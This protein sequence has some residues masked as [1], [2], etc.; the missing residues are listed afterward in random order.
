MI[1]SL[2]AE[3]ALTEFSNFEYVRSPCCLGERGPSNVPL[4]VGHFW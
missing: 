2:G 1:S 4:L 3:T